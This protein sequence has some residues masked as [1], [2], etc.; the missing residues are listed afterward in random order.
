MSNTK[1]QRI[2]IR[3]KG[4]DYR[5]VDRAT[6]DIVETAKRTGATVVG[7]IP[8]PTRKEKVTVLK[9][10]HVNK[11]AREQFEMRTH[12]RVIDIVDPT[13]NTIDRLRKNN[14]PS[15]VNVIIATANRN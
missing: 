6:Q 13:A 14:L 7:P 8:L 4:Y 12:K 5:V 1:N 11:T 15:G 9:S 3:L 2:R 10:P